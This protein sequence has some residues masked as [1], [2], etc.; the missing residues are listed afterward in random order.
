M[1]C[2]YTNQPEKKQEKPMILR[3]GYTFH[4]VHKYL[5]GYN[6]RKIRIS[7][8]NEKSGEFYA[9]SGTPIEFQIRRMGTELCSIL[10]CSNHSINSDQYLLAFLVSLEEKNPPFSNVNEIII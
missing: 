10:L 6:F 7:G 9:K 1:N 5:R 8:F 3:V 2:H 4:S